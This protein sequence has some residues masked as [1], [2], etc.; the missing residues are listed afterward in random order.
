MKRF[1]LTITVLTLACDIFGA[2]RVRP[3]IG[4]S[5]GYS[6][7]SAS[8]SLNASYYQAV[9]R[10]GGAPVIIPL[11]DNISTAEAIVSALGGLIMSGGEDVDPARYGESVWNETVGINSPRDT[12]DFLLLKAARRLGVPVLGICRGEQIVNV[13]YGGT[14]Y[15][16]LPSQRPGEVNHKQKESGNIATH[17]VSLVNGSLLKDIFDTDVLG[18]NTFH[19]QAVKEV[20]PGMKV[21]A[22]GPDGLVEGFEGKNVL[23]V[24]F[25]PEKFVADGDDTFLPIFNY[26][27]KQAS[28]TRIRR[29]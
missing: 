1:L 20:A 13:F 23:C 10:A 2:T 8:S 16:D 29:H 6:E 28:K 15:Q 9:E 5:S 24:Q 18:V 27:V 3:I 26:F 4:I 11:V 7:S 17:T 12:S 22:Y 19:H 14:L 21:N 25:H